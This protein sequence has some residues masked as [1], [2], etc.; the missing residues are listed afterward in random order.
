[1]FRPGKVVIAHLVEREYQ[2]LQQYASSLLTQLGGIGDNASLPFTTEPASSKS[3]G[4]VP[5]PAVYSKNNA[6]GPYLEPGAFNRPLYA[7][8]V[9]LGLLSEQNHLR[10]Q[11]SRDASAYNHRL[12][13]K[14]RQQPG[15]LAPNV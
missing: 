10:G 9:N 5:M 1:M 15:E 4:T 7:Y 3:C 13:R 12:P 6:S 2:N 11:P 8:A 14:R